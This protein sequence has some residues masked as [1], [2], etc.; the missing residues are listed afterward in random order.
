[1]NGGGVLDGMVYSLSLYCL[2]RSLATCM[3]RRLLLLAR[4]TSLG[5]RNLETDE[6]SAMHSAALVAPHAARIGIPLALQVKRTLLLSM[7]HQLAGMQ[8]R[9]QAPLPCV[10]QSALHTTLIPRTTRQYNFP[11]SRAPA[12]EV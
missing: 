9:A 8:Q 3:H 11:F 4:S 7:P 5:E 10:P 12:V 1:M 2:L 6:Q